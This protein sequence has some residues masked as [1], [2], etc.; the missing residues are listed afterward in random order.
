M[1]V[2]FCDHMP[3]TIHAANIYK[4]RDEDLR[5]HLYIKEPTLKLELEVYM[6]D[7][8]RVCVGVTSTLASEREGGGGRAKEVG[9]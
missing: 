4:S 6:R 9:E 7:D 5:E 2:E 8:G 3:Y 1:T